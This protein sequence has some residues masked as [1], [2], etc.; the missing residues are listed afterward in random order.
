VSP[1]DED[2]RWREAASLRRRF[3]EWV[4]IWLAR[5]AEFRAYRLPGAHTV[6]TVSAPTAGELA[7]RIA[8]AGQRSPQPRSAPPRSG[9][10]PPAGGW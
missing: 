9:N 2:D 8:T 7:A 6:T 1:G 4:V 5:T 10:G 3:P